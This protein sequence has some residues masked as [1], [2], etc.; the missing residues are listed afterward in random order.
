M[1]ALR[2]LMVCSGLLPI[3]P[4]KAQSTR[5]MPLRFQSSPVYHP[6][7]YYPVRQQRLVLQLSSTQFHVAR[8]AEIDL[9]SS[10]IHSAQ[11]L[12]L[13]R[14][15]VF[16]EGFDAMARDG[17]RLRMLVMRGAYCAFQPV[18]ERGR[19]SAL[20]YLG[21]GREESR[22]MKESRWDR[23][24]LCLL[25][26]YYVQ[27]TELQMGNVFFDEAIAEC[28]KDG[29]KANE[30]KAWAWRGLY[31]RYTPATTADRIASLQRARVLYRELGDRE[32]EINVLTNMGYLY[33]SEIR[34][35]QGEQLFKEALRLEDSIGFAYTH[36]TTENIAMAG[37][38]Q[39]RYGEPLS[40]AL[41]SAK[42]AEA[43]KDSVLWGPYYDRL[44]TLYSLLDN[45]T[46][47]C[48]KWARK[49][50]DRFWIEKDD[51]YL[52]VSL[53]YIVADKLDRNEA[54]M[55][56]AAVKDVVRER[57]PQSITG[58]GEYHFLVAR[59]YLALK[60][61]DSAEFHTREG[62]RL[63]AKLAV[64]HGP[65]SNA[66]ADYRLG[67]LYLEMGKNA[68]AKGYF[69]KYLS[70]KFAGNNL[71]TD[72]LVLQGL[73]KIDSASGDYR[74][75]A[76]RLQTYIRLQDSNF[77]IQGQRQGEELAV[78]YETER[79]E[80]EIELRDQR[81]AMLQQADQLRQSRLRQVVL[82]QRMTVGGIAVLLVIA[83]LLV[84]QN[85]Q[86]KKMN[87]VIAQML[88]DKEWLLKEVNHRVKNNLHTV[89]S[90]LETQA[91]HLK[92]EALEAIESSQ[93]RIY[94]MS[95]IHQKIYQAEISG[96]IEMSGYLREFIQYLRDSFG[97]PEGIRWWLDIEP[98]TLGLA[99]AVPVALIV[100]EAVTN[101]IKHAFPA[102]REGEIRIRV[103][104]DGGQV[105]LSVSDNGVGFGAPVGEAEL[106]TL[107]IGLMK[108]LSQELRGSFRIVSD[109]GTRV[110]VRFKAEGFLREP[111]MKEKEEIL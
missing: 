49:A 22:R 90:L 5:P 77:N 109:E 107:G 7:N 21:A 96:A 62:A 2:V 71:Q 38:F 97:G 33:I 32:G 23:Q 29:D 74:A 28:R 83:G 57:P 17:S 92:N 88:K 41:Q 104:L 58:Q 95:L 93:H 44:A 40:Y 101:S 50:F 43:L 66:Y 42:T 3:L 35:Q 73:A 48:S 36:Y 18:G 51:G 52:Y 25:G 64:L 8:N 69:Q 24:A 110:E 91:R 111:A 6:P 105:V 9:D 106:E 89:I 4:A 59:C 81:I 26:K 19:D 45:K 61:Y 79:K 13:S 37:T 103:G 10:L 82:V 78:K 87:A 12:G 34:L 1:R 55:A 84:R 20:Y 16:E 11:W 27:G 99:Q 63:T 68:R 80:Q 65:I 98:L 70:E 56:L 72:L 60:R 67:A 30:A 46:G 54:G 47:D 15:V 85:R 14:A 86:R 53:A 31:T 75:L 100:N 76:R 94:A 108:G 39:G 102:G